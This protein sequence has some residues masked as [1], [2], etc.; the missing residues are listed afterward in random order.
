MSGRTTPPHPGPADRPSPARG[1]GARASDGPGGGGAA[2][3]KAGCDHFLQSG[4]VKASETGN[5]AT[6]WEM[7]R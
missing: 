7:G 3:Y 1:E 6:A 5:L 2:G 4:A